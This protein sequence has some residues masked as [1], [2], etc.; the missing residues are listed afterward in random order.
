MC[1][2]NDG[3]KEAEHYLLL[4]HSFRVQ[5]WDFRASVLPVLHSFGLIDVPDPILLQILL[6]GDKKLPF[7]VSTIYSP[8]HYYVHS[9]NITFELMKMTHFR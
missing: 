5:K 8:S 1:P 6:Y 9:K 4:F 7:E 3:M 2:I